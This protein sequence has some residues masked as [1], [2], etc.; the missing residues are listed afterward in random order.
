MLNTNYIF[1]HKNVLSI[2]FSVGYYCGGA[3]PDFGFVGL[4]FDTRPANNWSLMT[5]I[6]Q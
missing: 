6:G 5:S 1:A 2:D 3:H 4:N